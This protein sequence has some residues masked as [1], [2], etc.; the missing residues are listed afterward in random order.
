MGLCNWF[1]DYKGDPAFL[2][3]E[4][5][6]P[7]KTF[8]L[9]VERAGFYN[10]YRRKTSQ[11]AP[12]NSRHSGKPGYWLQKRDAL[13]G[14][15]KEAL[16]E[17]HFDNQDREAI[18]ELKQYQ[19]GQ[20]GQPYH[21]ASKDKSDPS[22]AGAAHGDRII[23][24]ALAWH[25]SLVFGDQHRSKRSGNSQN[26]TNVNENNVPRNSFAWRRA[27]YLKEAIEKKRKSN[28]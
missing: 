20:D 23:S 24:D 19:I 1:S 22:G 8:R 16:L 14:P 6:G 28:W 25:A 18:E 3:W 27:Q 2:I 7:G 12:L 5:Q 17:G 4:D 9:R 13:L 21:V 15:Y 10:Y 26:V 11:D